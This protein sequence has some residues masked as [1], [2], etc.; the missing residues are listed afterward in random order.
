M[1]DSLLAITHSVWVSEQREVAGSV[2][3]FRRLVM[4]AGFV[5]GAQCA[6]MAMAMNSEECRLLHRSVTFM[7]P[8]IRCSGPKDDWLVP[9][10]T[11]GPFGTL[12]LVVAGG[13]VG[14]FVAWA[15]VE[16]LRRKFGSTGSS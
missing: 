1:L 10:D 2:L 9:W 16:A 11:T 13:V 3:V 14:A 8:G 12:P 6:A 5:L 15:L 7:P 4:L